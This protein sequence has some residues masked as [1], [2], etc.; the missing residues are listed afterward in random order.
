MAGDKQ[1]TAAPTTE[2][3]EK[4][5]ELFREMVAKSP[6][7]RGGEQ[8]ARA[9]YMKAEAFLKVREAIQDGT[10]KPSK[11]DASVLTDCCAPNLHRSHP[12]NL[13]S[14]RFGDLS[15]VGKIQ[16]WLDKNPTPESDPDQL[17]GRIK[18]A[19]PEL[20]WDTP[21][22]NTARAIFPQYVTR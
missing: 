12:Y 2:L 16:Q 17:V 13:V 18:D 22:I 21:A 14:R 10:I 19:F 3:D 5:F 8:Q 7:G 20:S 11:T 15:K 6:T 1:T 4:A 9:A